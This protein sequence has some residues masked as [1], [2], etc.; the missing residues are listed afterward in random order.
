MTFW[1]TPFHYLVDMT[2]LLLKGPENRKESKTRGQMITVEGA[3]AIQ[4]ID[5]YNC[6]AIT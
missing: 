2:E 1:H 4:C 3:V 5:K 6:L